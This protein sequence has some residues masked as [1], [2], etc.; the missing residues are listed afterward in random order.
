VL[1]VISQ[2]RTWLTATAVSMLIFEI[3]PVI[4]IVPMITSQI[5]FGLGWIWI[6]VSNGLAKGTEKGCEAFRSIVGDVGLNCM[7]GVFGCFQRSNAICP[8]GRGKYIYSLDS[9]VLTCAVRASKHRAHCKE[10][11][12]TPLRLDYGGGQIARDRRR[13]RQGNVTSWRPMLFNRIVTSWWAMGAH[14]AISK[15]TS[16][17]IPRLKIIARIQLRSTSQ[18]CRNSLLWGIAGTQVL[19]TIEHA[20]T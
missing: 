5:S 15:P 10:N 3:S 17:P 13:N 9:D 11:Y 1:N 7:R 16:P 12:S 14:W 18:R 6:G 19:E 8:G 4:L 20:M 2:G